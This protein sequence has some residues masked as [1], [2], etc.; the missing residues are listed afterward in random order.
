[1]GPLIESW[2]SV[3]RE[4]FEIFQSRCTGRS[5]P[6]SVDVREWVR[7]PSPSPEDPG[8]IGDDPVTS[9]FR[10]PGITPRCRKGWSP[11]EWDCR[12]T[13]QAWFPPLPL[14]DRDFPPPLLTSRG[15]GRVSPRQ[16]DED[17][18]GATGRTVLRSGQGS[19]TQWELVRLSDERH[20][21]G[22]TLPFSRT[23]Q[24]PGKR[25]ETQGDL[26]WCRDFCEEEGT[27][28]WEGPCSRKVSGPTSHYP[29]CS[30]PRGVRRV[31]L[32]ANQLTWETMYSKSE[33]RNIH[34]RFGPTLFVSW[35]GPVHF[36]RLGE[37][38]PSFSCHGEVTQRRITLKGY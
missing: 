33:S 35:G 31:P 18:S 7:C 38:L 5:W 24:E 32:G 28:E 23:Y 6:E 25:L 17:F 11:G 3:V 8:D 22:R 27:Q 13:P 10:C 4:L 26:E 19:L 12:G 34:P 20:V 9:T 14:C 21:R 16:V 30:L 36:G 1:M 29:N 2:T 15:P 37:T